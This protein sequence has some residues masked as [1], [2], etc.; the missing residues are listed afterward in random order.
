MSLH[1][2]DRGKS[3]YQHEGKKFR[4]HKQS[5]SHD[6]HQTALTKL[7]FS[8]ENRNAIGYAEH[9]SRSHH[10]IIR[11]YDEPGN[12]IETHKHKGDFEDW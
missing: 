1:N 8:C 12:L 3:D 6:K 9:F 2:A 10:A 11:V 4:G 7:R 5:I